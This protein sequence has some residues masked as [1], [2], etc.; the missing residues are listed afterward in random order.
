MSGNAPT[1]DKEDRIEITPEIYRRLYPQLYARLRRLAISP[2]EV[3]DLIQETF[4]YA[5]QALDRGQFKGDSKLDTWI[6]SI[7]KGRALKYHRHRN[8]VKRSADLVPLEQQVETESFASPVPSPL[9]EA[10]GRQSLN[11]TVLALESLPDD[12]RA[13]LMLSVRGLSYRQIAKLLRM[14]VA[15]VTSRIHQARAK[16]HSVLARRR[17]DSSS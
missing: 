13:P 10:S 11:Q 5:Q 9:Q 6:V 7:A 12:F 16:L 17:Q 1:D 4:L 3:E 15:R 2:Q 8:A 14:P